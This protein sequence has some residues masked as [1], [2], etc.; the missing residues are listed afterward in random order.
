MVD[1]I[2][3]AMS[4]TVLVTDVNPLV[5]S[6]TVL[7][8][9]VIPP[10]VCITVLHDVVQFKRESVVKEVLVIEVTSAEALA[11]GVTEYIVVVVGGLAIVVREVTVE[12]GVTVGGVSNPEPATKVL[13]V[14]DPS[15]QTGEI[16][17]KVD[18]VTVRGTVS[19][20]PPLQR[21]RM[22]E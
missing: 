14:R 5:T 10:P 2:P 18:S 21:K 17:E 8:L 20:G 4:V 9:E 22:Q 6:V 1:G 15:L 13:K 19:L 3:L 11:S 16:S 12:V 7:V